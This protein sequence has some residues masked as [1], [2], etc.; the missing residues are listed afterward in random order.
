M[1]LDITL[2][3]DKHL[4]VWPGDTPF[5]FQWK[6]KMSEGDSVNVGSVEMSIHTGTHVDAPYHFLEKGET[7]DALA[8][9]IY[10]GPAL[11]VDAPGS[12][13]IGIESLGN[14]DLGPTPRVLFRTDAWQD[15]TRFPDTFPIME[16]PLIDH[17]A[18]QGVRLVGID[19]PSVDAPESE[20]LPNHHHLAANGIYILESLDLR[21]AAP[22]RYELIALPLKLSGADGS[23]VRA[24]LRTMD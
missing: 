7:T 20:S 15:H 14:A 3:V 21:K 22:G 24:V 10:I 5:A 16:E 6:W 13:I 11:V 8:P 17:L 9:E 1:I 2:R 4:A 12:G 19:L 18:G 23:P